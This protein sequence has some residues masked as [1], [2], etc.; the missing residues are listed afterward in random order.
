MMNTLYNQNEN[1]GGGGANFSFILSKIIA[2]VETHQTTNL[3]WKQL[4]S[5]VTYIKLP[6]LKIACGDDLVV[7]K[8]K[9]F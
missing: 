6:L 7:G 3:N 2:R 5:L 9:I 4:P 1:M 8:S